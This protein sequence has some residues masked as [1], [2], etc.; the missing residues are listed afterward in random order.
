MYKNN[1]NRILSIILIACMV[2]TMAPINVF[3]ENTNLYTANTNFAGYNQLIKVTDYYAAFGSS[4]KISAPMEGVARFAVGYPADK[5]SLPETGISLRDLES[6]IYRLKYYSFE[7]KYGEQAEEFTEKE[8]FSSKGINAQTWLSQIILDIISVGGDPSNY[9]GRNYVYEL[10]KYQSKATKGLFS[11]SGKYAGS[12]DG[13][14]T[15]ALN[16]YWGN[17][18]ALTDEA[19]GLGKVAAVQ[20][21]MDNYRYTYG[22]ADGGKVDSTFRKGNEWGLGTVS[23]QMIQEAIYYNIFW[24]SQGVSSFSYDTAT[25]GSAITASAISQSYLSSGI[26]GS[27][28]QEKLEDIASKMK[29]KNV[30]GQ[31]FET[32]RKAQCELQAAYIISSL[33]AGIAVDDSE[34]VELA[35]FQLDDGSYKRKVADLV[36]NGEA[37]AMVAIALDYGNRVSNGENRAICSAFNRLQYNGNTSSVKSDI[38]CVLSDQKALRSSIENESNF[39]ALLN[40]VR[41][42]CVDTGYKSELSFFSK[43]PQG[44]LAYNDVIMPKDGEPDICVSVVLTI[45]HGSTMD[46]VESQSFVIKSEDKTFPFSKNE[47]L[48][49][50]YYIGLI[51]KKG[52][53]SSVEPVAV[54][55]ILGKDVLSQIPNNISFYP[56]PKTDRYES[57]YSYYGTSGTSYFPEAMAIID[58]IALGKNP[59]NYQRASQGIGEIEKVDLVNE[60]LARQLD[61]GSFANNYQSLGIDSTLALEIFFNGSDWGN[62]ENATQKGRIG[63]IESLLSYMTDCQGVENGRSYGEFLKDNSGT[64]VLDKWV[65]WQSEAAILLS[66]WLNDE[67]IVTVNGVSG[68]LKVF[69]QKEIDGLIKTLNAVYDGQFTNGKCGIRG[70][71]TY[72]K[73]ISALIACGNKQTIDDKKVWDVLRN[74]RLSNGTYPGFLHDI[75][76][77]TS[78][79]IKF[80]VDKHYTA[81]VAM[82]MGDY[83]NNK[84]LLSTLSFDISGVSDE[85]AVNNDLASL[86]IPDTVTGNLTLISKGFYGSNIA[87][88]SS[89]NDIINQNTGIVTRPT[90]GQANAVVKLTATISRNTYVKTYDFYVVVLS[91]G[92]E[93]QE[94]VRA[95]YDDLNVPPYV[96]ADLSLP[97]KGVHGSDI[98][99]QSSNESVLSNDGKVTFK[100]IETKLVLTA[101]VSKGSYTKIKEFYITVSKIIDNNNVVEKAINQLREVYNTKRNLTGIYWDVFAAKSVLGDDFDKYNF[102][103]YDVKSHRKGSAWQGTDYAAI[104]LQILSQGDNPYNYQG[105]NYV[106]QLLNWI[107][108]NGWGAWGN[109]S[110]TLMALDAAAADYEGYTFSARDVLGSYLAG[111]KNLQYGPDLAGWALIPLSSHINDDEAFRDARIIP[112]L[113]EF[114]LTLKSSQEKSGKNKGLFNTGGV[115]GGILTLSNGC[116]VSGFEALTAAG[117]SGFDLT[118][119][120]W[121]ID[122]TGVLEAIYNIDIVGKQNISN[123]EIIEFG[124]VYYGDSLWKRVGIKKSDFI[125][126]INTANVLVENKK[127]D[128]TISSYN[129]LKLAYDSAV[130]VNNNVDKMS[131]NYYGPS[132]FALRDAIDNLKPAGVVS[133]KILGDKNKEI[134]IESATVSKTGTVLEVIEEIAKQN[135][136]SLTVHDNKI[137]EIGG[138]VARENQDW[139]CYEKILSGTARITNPLNTYK[140]KEGTDLIFKYCSDTTSLKQDSTLEEHLVHDV[141]DAIVIEGAIDSNYIVTGDLVLKNSGLFGTTISWVSNKPFAIDENGK[142]NRDEKEDVKVSL[143][144][145]IYLNGIQIEKNYDVIVKSISGGGTT[146]SD[147]YAYISVVGPVGTGKVFFRKQAIKIEPGETAFSLLEKTNL[148]LDVD[149]N[150]QYGVYVSGIEGLSEMD[151]GPESG[152][153]YRVNGV[154]PSHSAALERVYEN[155]YVEWLYTRDLGKD[156]GGYMPGVENGTNPSQSESPATISAKATISNGIATLITKSDDILKA[157]EDAKKNNIN[158]ISIAPIIEGEANKVNV[159]ID[160]SSISKIADNKSLKLNIITPIATISIPNKSLLDL[161]KNTGSVIMI[162]T[163]KNTDNTISVEVR[164]G[165]KLLDDLGGGIAIALSGSNFNNS[166]VLA[167]VCEDDSIKIIK[168]AFVE[169]KNIYGLVDGSVTIKIIDNIKMFED[170]SNNSWYS[171]AVLFAA[172]HELFGGTSDMLFSPN[173][174]MSRAMLVTVLHRLEDTPNIQNNN[175]NFVDVNI[176]SYYGNAVS[177]ATNEKLVNGTGNAFNPNND[178]TREELITILYRYAKHINIDTSI[179]NNDINFNDENYISEWAYEAMSWAIENGIIAGK[180]NRLID[181]KGKSTRA[182]VAIILERFIKNIQ[183]RNLVN[184][185]SF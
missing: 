127:S 184:F 46:I 118:D 25:T 18:W 132:Y 13:L 72:S 7:S 125:T 84:A 86:N 77:P 111:L 168:K 185:S 83:V 116:V 37:T 170:I 140:I 163:T 43:T 63:A 27:L 8:W 107:A 183:F 142:V 149:R 102:K 109:P 178:I 146:P 148:S 129:D 29:N 5:N 99:W 50:D 53:T 62:D 41:A 48:L 11:N 108:N 120:Y 105:V 56:V 177:W 9:G 134:I 90:I 166:T 181:P 85:D 69:V 101:A 30:M 57:D 2:I 104:V 131:K 162:T 141:K 26:D 67:T 54:L 81:Y 159:Q 40:S 91:M 34:W 135:R 12:A 59:K 144:A 137:K 97:I 76:N 93:E 44:I 121:K 23:K 119:N 73:Y 138:L 154:F 66:R 110:W 33:S 174:P 117:L 22:G 80:S 65:L 87:W 15:L 4:K 165:N 169:G 1:V 58:E 42:V 95:D 45:K 153:L 151:E 36:S 133:V 112:A 106:E 68:E 79:N 171:K 157:I 6:E 24:L 17:E 88:A 122:G 75:D 147:K 172:S 114:R 173:I 143:T 103:V 98:T 164:V 61:N 179:E 10:M 60:L 100:D 92:S 115:E 21:M 128:Y 71:D 28:I 126:L 70:M 145:K 167:K 82:A 94:I 32:I 55:S 161:E 20:A 96:T 123:Q 155:D 19:E 64:G 180:E 156:V 52:L 136:I 14:A 113:E 49:K 152:W 130:T 139:Y 150:T 175:S 38:A 182:E 89:N 176:E 31:S 74:S 39:N 158:S 35:K 124:D 160:K 51:D 16:A 3:A 78:Q 47:K